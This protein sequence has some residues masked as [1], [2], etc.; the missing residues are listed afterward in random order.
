MTALHLKGHLADGSECVAIRPQMCHPLEC[1]G[2]I[3]VFPYHHRLSPRD[4]K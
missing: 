3:E 2:P 4:R 1:C